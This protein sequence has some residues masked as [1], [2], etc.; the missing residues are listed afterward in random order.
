MLTLFLERANQA[1]PPLKFL[2]VMLLL[3]SSDGLVIIFCA[4]LSFAMFFLKWDNVMF[5][6]WHNQYYMEMKTTLLLLLAATYMMRDPIC[7]SLHWKFVLLCFSFVASKTFRDQFLC[8][9]FPCAEGVTFFLCIY[10]FSC[11]K[12]CFVQNNPGVFCPTPHRVSVM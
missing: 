5:Q 11:M 4:P 9:S 3:H 8:R 10:D 12:T 6:C 1:L 7:P 2:I